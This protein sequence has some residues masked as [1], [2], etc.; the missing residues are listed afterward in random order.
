MLIC[1]K[2]HLKVHDI[3]NKINTHVYIHLLPFNTCI[4]TP[5]SLNP[6]Q[7]HHPLYGTYIHLRLRRTL[8]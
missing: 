1:L 5:V 3:N 7:S 2:H 6:P 8:Y 4:L